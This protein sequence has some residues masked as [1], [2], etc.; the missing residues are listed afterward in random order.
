MLRAVDKTGREITVVYSFQVDEELGKFFEIGHTI[1]IMYPFRR[2]FRDGSVGVEVG[3]GGRVMVSCV[4]S[5]G[6]RGGGRG[7]EG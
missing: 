6:G 3:E 5:W 7:R 2:A 1:A 4:Q